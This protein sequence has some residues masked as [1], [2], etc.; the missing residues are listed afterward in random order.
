MG[1]ADPTALPW[2]GRVG[3]VHTESA[4]QAPAAVT[5]AHRTPTGLPPEPEDWSSLGAHRKG[6]HLPYLPRASPRPPQPGNLPRRKAFLRVATGHCVSQRGVVSFKGTWQFCQRSWPGRRIASA[7]GR[8]ARPPSPPGCC[9]SAALGPRISEPGGGVGGAGEEGPSA[10]G[11][12]LPSPSHSICIYHLREGSSW[13]SGL[14]TTP[15]G[16]Q[17]PSPPS[18]FLEVLS[19]LG[20]RHQL[21]CSITMPSLP[22]HRPPSFENSRKFPAVEPPKLFHLASFYLRSLPEVPTIGSPSQSPFCSQTSP[23]PLRKDLTPSLFLSSN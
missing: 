6:C 17:S 19:A 18:H 15:P 14:L 13:T 9:P 5:A 16:V 12:C 1:G 4:G 10:S 3:A 23:A 2:R 22:A 7:F 21:S 8:G 20:P 11:L